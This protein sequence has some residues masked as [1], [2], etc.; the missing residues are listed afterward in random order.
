MQR[1]D[2]RSSC[3]SVDSIGGLRQR[4]DQDIF[5]FTITYLLSCWTDVSKVRLRSPNEKGHNGQG[6]CPWRSF[7]T[8]SKMADTYTLKRRCCEWEANNGT[9]RGV[10]FSRRQSSWIFQN[11]PPP[12]PRAHVGLVLGMM[13]E[14]SS[15]RWLACL[16]SRRRSESLAFYMFRRRRRDVVAVS[17]SH[18]ATTTTS[19]TKISHK[20]PILMAATHGSIANAE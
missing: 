4:V 17:S 2:A 11:T 10:W 16:H 19:M 9:Q 14:S 8:H 5:T 1:F 3:L 13:G 20:V 7:Q 6:V 18:T 15:L 12:P